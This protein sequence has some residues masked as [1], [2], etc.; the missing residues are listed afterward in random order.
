MPIPSLRRRLPSGEDGIAMVMVV[1]SMVI[2]SLFA[3]A[4]LGYALNTQT[5][6]RVNQD[7]NQAL[8]AAQAGVDDYIGYL[9]RNDAYSLSV[10]CSNT[11]LRGSKTGVNTCGWTAATPPGYKP[12]DAGDP[13]GPRF[14]YDVDTTRLASEGVVLVTSTGQAGKETRSLQVG[15]GRGGSADFLYYTDRED[16]DPNNKQAYPSGMN[17]DCAKYWWDGRSSGSRSWGCVEITFIGG[18][19]LDGPVHTNDTPYMT[20]VNGVKPRFVQGLSTSD[21]QCK[22]AVPTD[23]STWKNCDR[24]RITG[25]YGPGSYPAYADPKYLPDNSDKF[26]TYPGCQYAGATRIKFTAD[27]RMTV[28]SA[29]TTGPAACGGDAPNGVSVPVPTDQVIYVKDSTSGKR[30]CKSGEIG[31]GLPLGNFTGNTRTAFRYDVNMLD[32][33]RYCGNGNAYIEGILKGRVTVATSNSVTVTGDLVLAGGLAGT[34]ML[35]LVAAN[36]VEVFHPKMDTYE[37]RA[38]RNGICQSF[39]WGGRAGEDNR[40]PQRYNDPDTGGPN[41]AS[42][43]QIAAAIQTLQNSFFVQ[44]YDFGPGEGQLYVRGAI[45]QKWRG[46]VGRGSAGYLKNYRYDKRLKYAAPPYFPQWTDAKWA[47]KYTGEVSPQY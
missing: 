31:D 12:I 20:A 45:A 2:A 17:P 24:Y 11:A 32:A 42:G 19:V 25:D 29:E 22:L 15:V 27:G 39:G 13:S 21:P 14:H 43:I 36:S 7:W 23:S 9:N 16:A 41:P 46:I 10:D 47:G 40:W 30:M 26:A 18:D 3:F 4:A 38:T 33:T 5:A 37:C 6:S 1:S 44:S 35:G 28:W 8:A 34:D